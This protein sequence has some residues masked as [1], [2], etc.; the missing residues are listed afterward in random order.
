MVN[1]GIPKLDERLRKSYGENHLAKASS[2]KSR[3]SKKSNGTQ[4]KKK[5]QD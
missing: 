1:L 5:N 2:K 3:R 4:T